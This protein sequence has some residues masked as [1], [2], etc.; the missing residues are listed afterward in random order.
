MKTYTLGEVIQF[1]KVGQIAVKV[2]GKNLNDS[3]AEVGTILYFDEKDDYALKT[4][5][6]GRHLIVCKAINEDYLS[7]YIITEPQQN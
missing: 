4:K 2:E 3:F 5:K 1:M 6:T 7:K